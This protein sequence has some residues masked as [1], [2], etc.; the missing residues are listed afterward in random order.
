MNCLTCQWKLGIFQP[1]AVS[2][3]GVAYCAVCGTTKVT[4]AA[5]PVLLVRSGVSSI[6][7]VGTFMLLLLST[8]I[9]DAYPA[10]DNYATF[11][12][13]YSLMLVY[14]GLAFAQFRRKVYG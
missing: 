9:F 4:K 14:F 2:D 10:L 6:L 1:M 11:T 13:V 3:E 7:F 12:A 5:P 8:V